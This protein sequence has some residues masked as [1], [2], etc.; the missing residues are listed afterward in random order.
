MTY[1]AI[2]PRTKKKAP[3]T[4][5]GVRGAGVANAVRLK[6]LKS[7]SKG[8]ALPNV[9]F[10]AHA[11]AR[12][13][14]DETPWLAGFSGDVAAADHKVWFGAPALPMPRFVRPNHNN[15]V[16]VSTFHRAED[17]KYRRR[18]DCWAG[19]HMVL[20][21]D[22]G[23]KIPFTALH[24]APSCLVETS[25]GNF[26]AWLF[27]KEPERDQNKA[28][29]L[30]NGLIKAG[31]SDPGAGNLTR[32]GRLPTG[33]NG[34]A[35]YHDKNGQPFTQRVHIWAPD[36]RYTPAQIAQAYGFDLEAASKPRPKRKGAKPTGGGRYLEILDAAGLY[37]RPITASEGGH[38]IVCPWYE[39]HTDKDQ[40]GTAYWESSEQ[41][42]GRGGF[43]CMHG[44][45]AHRNAADLDYFIQ[46]L[47]RT[48]G[49]AAA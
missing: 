49:R 39:G 24:L 6:L 8:I 31:A 30:V 10:L 29:A 27:L 48:T 19:L 41:N 26:Q 35:K 22:L 47:L 28:E 40:T 37:I 4:R 16:C 5:P 32:Y 46:T 1:T 15:Y 17:G 3:A 13:G 25:P 11:F 7:S 38:Q 21:D 42:G 9:D 14:D 33:I 36:C 45:C 20:L 12:I 43:R 18:K 44:S 2:V 34:K 23:T